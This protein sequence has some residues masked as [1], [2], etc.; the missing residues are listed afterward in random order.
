MPCGSRFRFTGE[1]TQRG[2]IRQD[3]APQQSAVPGSRKCPLEQFTRPL[4]VTMTGRQHSREVRHQ[5]T[6]ITVLT[7]SRAESEQ[8][9][10]PHAQPVQEDGEVSALLWLTGTRQ[11]DAL[12]R[13]GQRVLISVGPGNCPLSRLDDIAECPAHD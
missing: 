5:G 1:Q 2:Q 13:P 10:F 3:L 6:G 7:A 8:G 12:K 11:V 9:L 4:I